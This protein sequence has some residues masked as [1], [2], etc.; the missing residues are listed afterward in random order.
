MSLV[1][2]GQNVSEETCRHADRYDYRSQLGIF[3]HIRFL[4]KSVIIVMIGVKMKMCVRV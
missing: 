4:S 3:R 1:I 2:C